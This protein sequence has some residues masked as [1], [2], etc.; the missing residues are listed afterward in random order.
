MSFS[1]PQFTP[2]DFTEHIFIQSPDATTEKV[3]LA[4]TAPE[5]YH[6]LSIYP[7]Y[8]KIN[9][10]W[11]LATESRMDCVAVK[12]TDSSVSIV[13]FR[14]LNVGDSVI[15][16]RSE[17]GS[18]GIYVYTKG[19]VQAGSDQQVFSFRQNRSRET[20]YSKD[21]DNL[22][23]LLEHEREHGYIVWVLG[24]AVVFDYDSRN[25]LSALINGGYVHAI[26]AGNAMATH[27]LEAGMFKTALG[28][29]I[30]TQESV[31]DAHYM[32]LDLINRTRKAGSIEKLMETS[33]IRDGIIYTA[34]RNN[35]PLVLAG[36]IRDDGP[37][38]SVIANN[39]EAQDQMRAHTRKATTL[40]C[41]ATQL[42]TIASGNMTPSYTFKDDQVR[43]VYIYSVD[44]AEFAVNKLR[45]R[46]TLEVTTIVTNIQDFL[47]HLMNKLT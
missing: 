19:F 7:E 38:P 34:I 27:D 2:P 36:S 45:D 28:Q 1:L 46:G 47:C 41:L 31:H 5:G 3:V 23:D 21:Y 44:I 37:L 15:I 4:G 18:D 6:A 22:Y 10:L 29:N 17:D 32:H 14:N 39:Y 24:P 25:A 9:G 13:E 33:D 40:I 42:H 12:N 20:A 11:K 26:L 43:P 16:G 8:F 30:Y 35:I